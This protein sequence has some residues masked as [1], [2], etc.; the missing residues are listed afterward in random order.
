MNLDALAKR[1]RLPW[2]PNP[3]TRDLDVW[4]EYEHPRAGTFTSEGK[5][6]FFMAVAVGENRVSV[7]AYTS[8]T[9]EE[10]QDLAKAEF[11]STA[12]LR[13]FAE[14]LLDGRKVVFALADDLLIKHW[15][16]A[17]GKGPVDELAIVFLNSVMESIEGSRDPSM[18]LRAKLAQVEVATTELVDA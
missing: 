3:S 11:D 13:E 12:S 17:D 1:G 6:V 14:K 8:L 9:S 2:S 10:A 16:V 18:M 4:E 7:W 5:T 15:S